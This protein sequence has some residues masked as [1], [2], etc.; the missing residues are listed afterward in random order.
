MRAKYHIVKGVAMYGVFIRMV[1]YTFC[2]LIAGS[3]LLMLDGTVCGNRIQQS[4]GV[5]MMWHK[6][7][8]QES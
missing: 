2:V 4:F 6:V 8:S 5:M 3:M 7:V 1:I